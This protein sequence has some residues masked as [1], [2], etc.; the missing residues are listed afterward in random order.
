MKLTPYE[1][2]LIAK[3]IQGK[4]R[5][6]VL[7]LLSVLIGLSLAFFYGWEAWHQ[8]DFDSGIHFVLVLF[9]LL[10][11]RQHLR[12]YRYANILSQLMNCS[13]IS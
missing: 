12:S 3:T 13:K 7:S 6:F 2:K 9:I 4:K 8:P 1:K 11:G 10:N 5:F